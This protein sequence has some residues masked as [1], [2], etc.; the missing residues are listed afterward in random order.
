MIQAARK[1]LILKTGLTETF[2]TDVQ[3]VT[4][5][6]LGDILRSTPLLKTFNSSD[7]IYWVTS[8]QGVPLLSGIKEI[9]VLWSF[10][11]FLQNTQEVEFDL[12][13]NL[14]RFIPQELFPKSSLHYGFLPKESEL[15]QTVS[16]VH[17]LSEYR[18]FYKNQNKHLWQN[19]LFGLL[20]LEYR[21]EPYCFATPSVSGSKTK[22]PI[23][24]LNWKVG[25]K[26]PTKEIDLQYW[27]ALSKNLEQAGFTAS[28]QEG[29]DH[30]QTYIDW[31]ARCD[32]IIT[33]DSLGLHLAIALRK[34]FIAFF[35][36][37][38]RQ[39]LDLYQSGTYIPFSIPSHYDCLPCHQ[40]VCHQPKICTS[41]INF[42]EIIS[43]VM[44]EFKNED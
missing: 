39:E 31:V 29:H 26:W 11:D 3:V 16:G 33:C 25:S 10:E 6:S 5:V 15:L 24:G 34:K 22:H 21:G 2:S 38:P 32:F 37:T 35:G 44:N 20:G 23:I 12:F 41:Y 18:Q 17:S 40:P 8:Q 19:L 9:K 28:W 1:I 7:E 13:I 43:T 36:P 14:E 4:V 30:L 42:S 27:Q